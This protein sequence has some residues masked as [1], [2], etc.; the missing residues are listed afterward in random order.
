MLFE[1]RRQRISIEKR[2]VRPDGSTVWIT[3]TVGLIR[4]AEGP[5]RALAV[6]IYVTDRRRAEQALC[7]MQEMQRLSA[8]AGRTGT[9]SMNL[10]TLERTISPMM[11]RLLGYPVEQSRVAGAQWRSNV[12]AEDLAGLGIQALPG[13]DCQRLQGGS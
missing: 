7:E 2:Y 9:W 3:N 5:P 6:T 13:A 10:A 8:E 11:A 1:V 12:A 4:V